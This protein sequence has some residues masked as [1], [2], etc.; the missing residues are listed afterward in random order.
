MAGAVAAF[1][2]YNI[3]YLPDHQSFLSE[4]PSEY[5]EAFLQFVAK[6]HKSYGTKEEFEYRLRT[7]SKNFHDIQTHNMMNSEDAGYSLALNKFSDL[8]SQEFKNMLGYKPELRQENKAPLHLDDSDLPESIDWRDKG[9]VTPVK[10]QGQCGSCWA[11]STTGSLE[12]LNMIKNGEL[13]SFSE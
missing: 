6:Y 9:A 10:N 3:N 7:F 4:A 2:L 11:F 8:T 5:Q 1:A 12:G 13:V